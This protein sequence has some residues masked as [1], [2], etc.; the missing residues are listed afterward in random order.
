MNIRLTN[1]D[2]VQL[3]NYRYQITASNGELVQE[4]TLKESDRKLEIRDLNPNDYYTIKIYADF[5]LEDNQGEQ[6]EQ[7]IGET[8][9]TTLP[10]SSLGYLVLNLET[11]ELAQNT[12]KIN[13]LY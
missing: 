8:T 3:N 1:H 11:Q 4:N 5:D 13:F 9:F 2:N 10:L 6:T 7:V 12:A